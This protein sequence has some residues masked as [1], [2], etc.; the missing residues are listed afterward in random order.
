MDPQVGSYKKLQLDEIWFFQ[1]SFLI[2]LPAPLHRDYDS[3]DYGDDNDKD[4]VDE[5]EVC[6]AA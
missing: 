4:D 3:C 2:G 1:P 5:A 6:E